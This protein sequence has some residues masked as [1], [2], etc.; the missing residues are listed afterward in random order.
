MEHQIEKVRD[1]WINKFKNKWDVQ[2]QKIVA[3]KNT[4]TSEL[5]INHTAKIKSLKKDRDQQIKDIHLEF[6][7]NISELK[8]KVDEK[9]ANIEKKYSHKLSQFLTAN[10]KQPNMYDSICSYIL[11]FRSTIFQEQV[12]PGSTSS[13]L[14]PDDLQIITFQDITDLQYVEPY[15]QSREG[16]TD[17]FV[18]GPFQAQQQATQNAR[19]NHLE[20]S[21]S[22]F[23]DTK[24]IYTEPGTAPPSDERHMI[25]AQHTY[26]R[27][28]SAPSSYETCPLSSNKVD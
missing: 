3:E 11:Y 4:A 22:L 9:K 26:P 25:Y 21:Q 5:A 16:F 13:D 27:I 8:V 23:D 2:I 20:K 10:L 24:N 19:T 14:P 7:T 18:V 28:A 6:S 17:G 12:V 1:E 15:P